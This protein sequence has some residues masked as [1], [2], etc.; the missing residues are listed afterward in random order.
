MGIC[1]NPDPAYWHAKSDEARQEARTQ[2]DP[3]SRQSGEDVARSYASM[4]EW[5]ERLGKQSEKAGD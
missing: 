5:A 2:T 1:V 3:D 4:A